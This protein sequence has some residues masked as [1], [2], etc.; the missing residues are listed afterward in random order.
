MQV[1]DRIEGRAVGIGHPALAAADPRD[2]AAHDH[3]NVV[4]GL[5]LEQAV[6]IREVHRSLGRQP[7]P[8]ENEVDGNAWA[9]LVTILGRAAPRVDRGL[10]VSVRDEQRVRAAIGERLDPESRRQAALP[11]GP[12]V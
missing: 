6:R 5:R 11:A 9:V 12:S 8:G 3:V 1:E 7:K 4:V 2:I 10:P